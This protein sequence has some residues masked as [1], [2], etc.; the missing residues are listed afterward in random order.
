MY[1]YIYSNIIIVTI[2]Y[3]FYFFLLEEKKYVVASLYSLHVLFKLICNQT[4]AKLLA[5]LCCFFLSCIFVSVIFTFMYWFFV[6]ARLI[7]LTN[8]Y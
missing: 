4:Y 6:C 8:I 3:L 5:H 7:M 2:I 1:I